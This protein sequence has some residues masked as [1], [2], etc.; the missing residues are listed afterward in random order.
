VITKS[1]A[2]FDGELL[3]EWGGPDPLLQIE[4]RDDDGSDDAAALETW[5]GEFAG[6]IFVK[7]AA[8]Q[9]IILWDGKPSRTQR[10]CCRWEP[11]G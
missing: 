1:G 8:V 9:T 5:A 6:D 3:V 10:P 11:A 4:L 7:P 2:K